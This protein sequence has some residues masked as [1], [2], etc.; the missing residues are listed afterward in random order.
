[1]HFNP[2]SAN[3]TKWLKTLKQ[4]VGNLP[5]NCLSVFDHFVKL[6]LK[7]LRNVIYWFCYSLN[8]QVFWASCSDVLHSCWSGNL[9]K[10]L[11][12]F[13]V[14]KLIYNK[15]A[16]IQVTTLQRRGFQSLVLFWEYL[17]IF[18]TYSDFSKISLLQSRYFL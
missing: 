18:Q 2:L 5:T 14:K 12:N 10:F 13:S 9:Q 16:W 8:P 6:A 11:R 7:G 17:E 3:P 15:V 4:F 1:M